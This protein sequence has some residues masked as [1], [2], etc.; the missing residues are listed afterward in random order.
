MALMFFVGEVKETEPEVHNLEVYI[1]EKEPEVPDGVTFKKFKGKVMLHSF[2]MKGEWDRAT[3]YKSP[4]CP[5]NVVD[6]LVEWMN[7]HMSLENVV[8]FNENNDANRP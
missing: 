3:I 5:Q 6:D 8:A 1:G 4:E 7:V 2:L